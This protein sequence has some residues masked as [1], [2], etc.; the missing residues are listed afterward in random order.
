MGRAELKAVKREK[1]GK[2][3]AK[4]LRKKEWI[5]AVIYGGKTGSMP[6]EIS[7][8]DFK[9]LLRT[10]AGG[11]VIIDL[12]IEGDKTKAHTVLIKELQQDPVT[13]A[14]QHVDF[15]AISLTEK[16]RIK[17][18]VQEKGES[19][20]VKEGGILDHIH[21]EVEVECLPTEIPPKIDVPVEHLKIG[22]SIFVKDLVFP[23]GVTCTM[24]PDDLIFTVLVPK[25]EEEVAP[26][27]AAEGAAAEEP[28]LI[29]KKKA[30]EGEVP[31]GEEKE[32]AA[33]KEEKKEE[34]KEKKE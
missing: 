24:S 19:V 27:A 28:E 31:A 29:R 34:K 1:L 11:N 7:L 15:K 21:R 6:L 13:G 32:K 10:G 26:A 8:Y 9:Q 4:K 23:E 17:V 18:P 5:P 12:K 30:E 22:D 14:V 33:P 20:G 25:K 16:I 2:E 3:Y